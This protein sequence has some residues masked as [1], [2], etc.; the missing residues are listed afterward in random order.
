[1]WCHCC[2]QIAF[3]YVLIAFFSAMLSMAI[4][5]LFLSSNAAAK[6]IVVSNDDG[7][8]T[9]QIRQMVNVLTEAKHN[10]STLPP[11]NTWKILKDAYRWC[12]PHQH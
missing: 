4:P 12:C 3:P 10:V 5:L 1:M 7:W 11:E 2:S 6:N 8:A 9:A